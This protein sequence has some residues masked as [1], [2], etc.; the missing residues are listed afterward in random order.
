[1]CQMTYFFYL[2][3]FFLA[4]YVSLVYYNGRRWHDVEESGGLKC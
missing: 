4:D 1:M 3:K 2:Q